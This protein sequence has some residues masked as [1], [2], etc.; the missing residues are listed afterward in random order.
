MTFSDQTNI[1]SAVGSGAVGQEVAFTFPI[2]DTSDL[3]VIMRV[4]ATGVETALAETTNYTVEIDGD[5]GGTLTTVTAIE[6]TEEIHLKRDTPM[7]QSLDLEQGGTFNAE[8]VEDALDKNTKLNIENDDAISRCIKIPDTDD[9]TLTVELPSSVD[10]GSTYIYFDS[11]GNI[12]TG[13]PTDPGTVV[14]GSFG[15]TLAGTAN[16]AAAYTALAITDFVVTLLN[17]ADAATFR[18]TIFERTVSDFALTLMDDAAA[19]NV[20]TTLGFSTFAKTIVDDANAA[21]ARVTMGSLAASDILT[22]E[23]DV[24]THDGEVLTY[25]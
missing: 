10:R 12:T 3:S 11:D 23:G 14:F 4:T 24:F 9:S 17:D 13:D 15:E 7:T 25:I 22:Y 19:T 8:N 16:V 20:L 18:N 21:A 1:T 5:S 6:T 2:S